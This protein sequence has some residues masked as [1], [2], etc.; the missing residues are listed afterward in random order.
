MAPLNGS[1]ISYTNAQIWILDL[2]RACPGEG[3][4]GGKN[5]QTRSAV[6]SS[7]R[8]TK[9]DGRMTIRFMFAIMLWFLLCGHVVFALWETMAGPTG[10]LEILNL[11]CGDQGRGDQTILL[12]CLAPSF[13]LLSVVLFGFLGHRPW[14]QCTAC[15]RQGRV[16][17]RTRDIGKPFTKEPGFFAKEYIK[18]GTWKS[19]DHCRRLFSYQEQIVECSEEY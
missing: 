12:L 9:V 6:T 17:E 11:N 18:K 1:L 5:M 7:A 4:Y 15:N 19:C 8:C 16:F 2:S 14:E 3:A 10:F 13:V